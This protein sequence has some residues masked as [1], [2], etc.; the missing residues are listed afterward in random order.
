MYKISQRGE[1]MAAIGFEGANSQ[2]TSD[3]SERKIIGS[4]K[5]DIN[6]PLDVL[7]WRD[8]ETARLRAESQLGHEVVA[9]GLRELA[10]QRYIQGYGPQSW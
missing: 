1:K 10:E 8:D 7:Q 3:G 9:R 2:Q 6:T 4:H 5:I